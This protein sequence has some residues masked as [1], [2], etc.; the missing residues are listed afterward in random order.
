MIDWKLFGELLMLEVWSDCVSGFD[1]LGMMN[2]R[3]GISINVI[4][5]MLSEYG[6]KLICRNGL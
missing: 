4:V 1:I 5:E 3:E 2:V 6:F